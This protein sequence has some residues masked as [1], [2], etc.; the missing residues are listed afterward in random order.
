MLVWVYLVS[1][2]IQKKF[3]FWPIILQNE[4]QKDIHS[5]FLILASRGKKKA[6]KTL[7]HPMKIL[8]F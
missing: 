3:R 2:F 8:A 7:T 5:S 6:Q 4:T 1:H